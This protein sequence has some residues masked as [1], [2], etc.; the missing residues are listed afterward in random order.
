MKKVFVAFLVSIMVAGVVLASVKDKEVELEKI[1]QY[2]QV[3]DQKIEVARGAN[4][5]NKIAAKRVE[6]LATRKSE[7]A[8]G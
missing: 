7:T 3:L 6:T 1:K 5:I 2:I 4:Q 8:Q